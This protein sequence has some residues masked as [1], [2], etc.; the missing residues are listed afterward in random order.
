MDEQLYLNKDA[1][2]IIGISPR[3]LQSWT[4]KGVVRPIREATGGGSKRGYSYLNLIEAGLSKR[5]IE[6]GL[7]IQAVKRI[8]TNIRE[9]NLIARWIDDPKEF[10]RKQWISG[11]LGFHGP[12]SQNDPEEVSR[13]QEIHASLREM[14]VVEPLEE[15]KIQGVL[16]YF[17]WGTFDEKPFIFPR[18]KLK[19]SPKTLEASRLLYSFITQ[20]EGLLIINIGKIKNRIDEKI[21]ASVK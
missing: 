15:K 20:Y 3:T 4:D 1:A 21:L 16:F 17:L 9:S 5:L 7:G 8:L 6:K 11:I 18:L 2:P 13:W 12:L 19:S 10:F 14:F